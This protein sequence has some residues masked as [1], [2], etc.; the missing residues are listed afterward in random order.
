MME[1]KKKILIISGTHGNEHSA[2]ELGLRLKKYYSGETN[3]HIRVVPFLNEPG[4]LSNTREVTHDTTADLN[5]SFGEADDSHSSIVKKVKELVSEYDYIIDIHNS[6]RC[7]NFC[8]VDAGKNE[9]I[10]TE[11][12]SNSKVEYAT[13]FSTGSTIK[14][15]CNSTGK[16][17]LTYEFSG[18]ST[19]NNKVELEK[20]FFDITSLVR[21]INIDTCEMTTPDRQNLKSMHC[22]ET[23]F[24]NFEKDI[25]DI[26]KP[27]ETVF[28]VID[29]SGF[30][31]E[32]VKNEYKKHNIKLM[33]LASSYQSRG[34]SVLQYIRKEILE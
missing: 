23:G 16:V 2:V 31:I 13:R 27:G 7:A 32:T 12:C 5:R 22:L 34:S 14:D 25:N 8:L 21:V 15:Y 29:A 24:I 28:E 11:L 19:L 18:M 3:H 20:A 1:S 4:L 26:V 30:V 10:I 17:G 33:A 6:H 9:D